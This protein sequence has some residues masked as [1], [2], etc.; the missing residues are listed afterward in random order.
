MGTNKAIFLD[1]DGTINVEKG[2]LYK[3]EDFE[4][5]PNV[6]AALQRLQAAGY[7]LI[8]IT[9]QSGIA[10]GYY[11]EEDYGILNNWMLEKLRRNG[12]NIAAVY[13]CPHHP[14][15]KVPRYRKDCDC[16]KP[17]LGMFKQAAADFNIDLSSSF[18]IGDK[19]RD[20]AIC[21]AS[22]CRGF[23]IAE[24]EDPETIERVKAGKA[25]NVAY[26]ADLYDAAKKILSP[27]LA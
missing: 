21:G 9:N 27:R 12:V 2:Y 22:S 6:I 25:D 23:L 16:R 8:I 18:A 4:L 7:L 3:A 13:H 26:A 1:R 19:I 11:T 17:K 15:A 14:D 20:C 10:R 24:N 5:L